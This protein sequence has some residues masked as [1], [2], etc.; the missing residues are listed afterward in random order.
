M[1]Y[2]LILLLAIGG[3]G[4]MVIYPEEGDYAKQD[5]LKQYYQKKFDQFTDIRS[6]CD[7]KFWEAQE[8]GNRK[9]MLKWH[10]KTKEA[11]DSMNKYYYLMYPEKENCNCK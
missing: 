1:K 9:E 7:N 4:E 3:C 11:T 8:V 10:N 5:T 6:C 2:Y